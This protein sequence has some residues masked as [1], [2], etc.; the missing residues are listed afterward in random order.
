MGDISDMMLD[1]T[2]CECCGVYL[3]ESSQGDFSTALSFVCKRG[4]GSAAKTLWKTIKPLRTRCTKFFAA[5]FYRPRQG[6]FSGITNEDRYFAFSKPGKNDSVSS[7]FPRP[8][9][10]LKNGAIL[11]N[12]IKIIFFF[13]AKWYLSRQKA[14]EAAK[15]FAQTSALVQ[16]AKRRGQHNTPTVV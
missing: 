16:A 14:S 4:S 3:G 9:N 8:S 15:N 7:R 12:G 11:C 10:L 6:R 5:E 13:M 1:G 2:L